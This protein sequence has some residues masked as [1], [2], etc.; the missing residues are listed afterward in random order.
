LE[1]LSIECFRFRRIGAVQFDVNEGFVIVVLPV[2][3]RLLTP[4]IV[5]RSLRRPGSL[6][7]FQA[8]NAASVAAQNARNVT[9]ALA[10]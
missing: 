10:A 5:C 7:Q 9:L 6:L 2:G 1:Q 3:F 4:G 8:Y